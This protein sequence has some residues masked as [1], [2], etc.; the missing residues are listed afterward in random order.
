MDAEDFPTSPA[1]RQRTGS[2]DEN[3]SA[4]DPP[5]S[6]SATEQNGPITEQL[7]AE[8]SV[9][10][11]EPEPETSSSDLKKREEHA[12]PEQSDS[13][14]LLDALMLQVEAEAAA[15]RPSSDPPTSTNGTLPMA[16]GMLVDG[17]HNRNEDRGHDA[18]AH[19]SD[20]ATTTQEPAPDA[21]VLGD[22]EA[23]DVAETVVLDRN[24]QVA[25]DTNASVRTVGNAADTPTVLDL[26]PTNAIL[27]DGSSAPEP[28][29]EGAEWEIDSS[30][31]ESSSDS[32]S[33]SS[34][35]TSSEEDSDEDAD[36][37]YA[38]LD[39]E[40]TA[41]ILMQGD[42]GSD[43][44][45]GGPRDRK[46][47]GPLRTA[48]ER[49]EEVIPR[50]DITV[51]EDM[52]I[53][54]LGNVEFVVESTVVVKAK[55]S[56]EYQVLE[57]G[58]LIC[59]KDRSVVGV[60]ADL[61]GRVEEPRYTIRFTNDDDIKEAGVSEAGVIV[62]YVPEHSTFVFTQPL[63][64]VKG[65]D[66]SNF[67]D[68][69]VG[70][71][72]ME[73]SDDEAEAEHRRQIKAKRQGRSLDTGR[74]RGNSKFARGSHR[75]G[76]RGGHHADHRHRNPSDGSAYGN[77]PLE[78]NYDDVPV[79][80]AGDDGYT[81]LQRPSDLAE[82]VA[83]REPPREQPR[84][85]GMMHPLPPPPQSSQFRGGESGGRGRGYGHGRGGRGGRGDRGGFRPQRGRGGFN[86]PREPP[87]SQYNASHSNHQNGY[88]PSTAP[89]PNLNL[90]TTPSITPQN[91]TYP[92]MTPSPITP[93]PNVPFNFGQGFQ[94]PSNF[95]SFA[96]PPGVPP[97]PPLFPGS[98]FPFQ[99]QQT[100]QYQG[101]QNPY[102]SNSPHAAGGQTN[103]LSG[104][105]A[106]NPAIAA[107]LQRQVE[108]QRRAQGQQ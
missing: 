44:E 94:P 29:A 39:P 85:R 3:R 69:E 37:D 67:H 99:Q 61:I 22:I 7:P 90:P 102:G 57:P 79:P 103:Y 31:Y 21:T 41:R 49:T 78:I 74:G 51:T 28:G 101:G 16:D 76:S 59:L 30:P 17:E 91:I 100:G 9:S 84:E 65:S 25:P 32:D 70:E 33:D 11:A 71:D 38:M 34:D 2:P 72:E 46:E 27:P 18:Q 19:P 14:S 82:M 15:A 24:A 88:N 83:K 96:A 47:G 56:G 89:L 50:P 36:G 108:E 105:W 26:N 73:F 42:A 58:S 81:P 93:L 8:Q 40:E 6:T 75:G 45:G 35:D 77:G 43:D 98:N 55:T 13:N 62:F 104:A 80:D 1:K 107:A 48:N 23:M 86:Q 60:V 92:P 63:K 20:L 12:A 106:G 68:E 53:E 97:P 52:K 95:P 10:T 5:Q 54:E 4:L 64:S 87:F 66:A